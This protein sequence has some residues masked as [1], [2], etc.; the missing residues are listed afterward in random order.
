M[1]VGT[2]R[3]IVDWTQL[4]IA[5]LSGGG[6]GALVSY[7]TSRHQH[8]LERG[9]I[10]QQVGDALWMR[11]REEFARLND[12]VDEL[13]T[14]NE[15]VRQELAATKEELAETKVE[16]TKAQRELAVVRAENDTLIEANN[17]L[18]E[19]L[20]LAHK[21]HSQSLNSLLV[22]NARLEQELAYVRGRVRVVTDKLGK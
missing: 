3:L 9:R 11:T 14:E 22:V 15:A 16:L 20:Y 17:K 18:R 8:A 4:L 12:D 6:L 21:Q 7:F 13:R 10:E 2:G 1:G 5:L 19:D